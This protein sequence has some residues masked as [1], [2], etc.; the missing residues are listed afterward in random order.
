[1]LT[2]VYRLKAITITLNVFARYSFGADHDGAKDG[3]G[4]RCTVNNFIM[5]P[6]DTYIDETTAYSDN[7]WRFSS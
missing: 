4:E 2:D 6:A 7:P 3:N 5:A 1:M